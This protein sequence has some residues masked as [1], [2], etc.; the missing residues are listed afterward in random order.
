MKKIMVLSILAALLLLGK[1]KA[2]HAPAEVR[3]VV[4]GDTIFQVLP[5]NAIPAIMK[6]EY[7]TGKAADR[8]MRKDEPVLGVV[9]NGQ[10]MAY[11]LW[12]LDSHEIVNDRI[13]GVP[14]AITW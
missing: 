12:Q 6:P 7:V 3:A 5:P 2:Q 11:S 14:F 10:A 4:E 8:Q 9:I 1:L 13:A